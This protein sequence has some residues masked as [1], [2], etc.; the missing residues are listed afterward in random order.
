MFTGTGRNSLQ[1][2]MKTETRPLTINFPLYF[3]YLR[4]VRD[5]G[6]QPGKGSQQQNLPRPQDPRCC[7]WELRRDPEGLLATSTSPC[8]ATDV[9]NRGGGILQDSTLR[10]VLILSPKKSHL[11]LNGVVKPPWFACLQDRT[12]RLLFMTYPKWQMCMPK[13]FWFMP[14]G[15]TA[16]DWEGLNT[17]PSLSTGNS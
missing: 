17:H 5:Q 6:K 1:S 4:I 8:K 11:N 10:V 9:T 2:Q 14:S 12:S 16:F 7:S 13:P 15:R 3:F